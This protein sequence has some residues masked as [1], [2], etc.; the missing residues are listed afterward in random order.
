[1]LLTTHYMDEAD[2][3]CSRVAIMHLGRVAAIGTPAELKASI[4]RENVTLDEVF[5]HYTGGELEEAGGAYRE[6]E[7]IRRTTRRLG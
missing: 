4:G 5:A 3:V 6:T 7:R 1:M 2:S